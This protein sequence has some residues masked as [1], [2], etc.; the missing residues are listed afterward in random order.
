VPIANTA[1][2]SA[3]I[4]EGATLKV[5]PGGPHG[6]AAMRKDQLNADLLEF[7]SSPVPVAAG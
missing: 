4:I 6:L 2:R 3:K 7:V 1:H 5:Y